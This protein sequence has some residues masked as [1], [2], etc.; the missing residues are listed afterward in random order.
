MVKFQKVDQTVPIKKG[1]GIA[2]F[3]GEGKILFVI[4]TVCTHL[5]CNM[6]ILASV[7]K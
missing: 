4:Y 6:N 5:F 7:W 3:Q 2:A 1:Q